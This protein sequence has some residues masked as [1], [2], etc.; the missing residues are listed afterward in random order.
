MTGINKKQSPSHSKKAHAHMRPV[1]AGERVTGQ[2]QSPI[3]RTPSQRLATKLRDSAKGT[4]SSP[5]V[6]VKGGTRGDD[7]GS[8]NICHP[9]TTSAEQRTPRNFRPQ[10]QSPHAS[11]VNKKLDKEMAIGGNPSQQNYSKATP[12]HHGTSDINN[13]RHTNETLLS[14]V[15][16]E[17]KKWASP[18]RPVPSAPPLSTC[19]LPEQPTKNPS[20]PS[21]ST[22]SSRP[23][24]YR[25]QGRGGRGGRVHSTHQQHSPSANDEITVPT[26]FL[27]EEDDGKIVEAQPVM[28][29]RTKYMLGFGIILIVVGIVLGVIFGLPPPLPNNHHTRESLLEL[30]SSE[31]Q[32][33]GAAVRSEFSPQK[34]AFEWLWGDPNL[35]KYSD[36]RILERYALAALHESTGGEGWKNNTGWM[37]YDTSECDWA[38]ITCNVD[39][40]TV[41][42]LIADKNRME[43]TLPS[44]IFHHL[45]NLFEL[46]L[47]DNKLSG[48]LGD[49]L[50]TSLIWLRLHDTNLGGHLSN[51]AFDRLSNLRSLHLHR[52]TISGSIPDSIYNLEGLQTLLLNSNQMTGTIGSDIKVY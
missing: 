27:V 20:L 16:S 9:E 40:F 24:A 6:I 26:A 14:E 19:P 32:D 49:D 36:G 10:G 41:E 4:S 15:K 33:N 44:E 47:S 21:S 2:N 22:Q 28:S 37:S 31:S 1:R 38:H 43:G 46:D 42:T 18:I 11:T 7:G 5:T 23:G 3:I 17:G 50:G 13:I 8:A 30:I 12:H 48:T 45:K 34:S 51:S 39:S 25:V 35:S 29:S 52:S